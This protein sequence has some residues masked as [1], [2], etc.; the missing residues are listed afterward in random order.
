MT[1][2]CRVVYKVFCLLE[3][4]I[5]QGRSLFSIRYIKSV[6]DRV[7]VDLKQVQLEK[8]MHDVT[9][10]ADGILISLDKL[11]AEAIAKNASVS[12]P[13]EVDDIAKETP[14]EVDE[15]PQDY[16]QMKE[17]ISEKTLSP[18]LGPELMVKKSLLAVRAE[19]ECV[20]AEK[21]L[22]RE[23]ITSFTGGFKT[24]NSLDFGLELVTPCSWQTYV[25]EHSNN[26]KF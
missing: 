26:L 21:A 11:Y 24:V 5:N 22:L 18:L 15:R 25:R 3:T 6:E 1:P 20:S 2:E 8:I 16:S 14:K 4:H 9:T 12:A 19:R 7:G 10:S 13:E 23:C 17:A